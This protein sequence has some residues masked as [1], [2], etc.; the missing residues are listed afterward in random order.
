MPRFVA[1]PR[2]I[3][4]YQWIGVH[5]GMPEDFDEYAGRVRPQRGSWVYRDEDGNFTHMLPGTFDNTFAPVSVEPAP[6]PVQRTRRP[7]ASS[8]LNLETEQSASLQTEGA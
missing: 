6:E 2:Q 8:I 4:A 1:R 7:R 5:G 3:V